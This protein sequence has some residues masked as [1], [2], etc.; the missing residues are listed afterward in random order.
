MIT[1]L[2]LLALALSSAAPAR[3]VTIIGLDY[4]FSAPKTVAAGPSVFRFENRGKKFHELNV[5]L[6]KRGATAKEYMDSV[7]AG[8]PTTAFRESPVGVLFAE[9]GKTSD[10]GLAVDL[11]EGRTYVVICIFRDSA[12]APRH[13]Q[14]GMSTV[15]VPTR[16]AAAVAPMPADTIVGNDYAFTR[17]PRTLS[18][19]RHRLAFT[20]EGKV[21]HEVSLGLLRR[22][23]S[24]KQLVDS[25]NADGDVD[26]L[27]EG[28]FGVLASDA[29]TRPIGLLEVDLKPGREYVIFCQ[30]SDDA[31]AKPHFMLGM[32]GSIVVRSAGRR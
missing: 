22:G 14:L 15:I 6:L 16:A 18:P 29:K 4:A 5:S 11:Q 10:A 17:Y 2:P 26:P 21:R 20:N 9:P 25:L 30:F 27:I 23:V 32:Y 8:K 19:G 24:L 28:A 3:D 1:A 13:H 7:R 12:G 31:K